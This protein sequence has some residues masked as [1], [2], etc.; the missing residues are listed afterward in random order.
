MT[1]IIKF[2]TPMLCLFTLLYFATLSPA[3]TKNSTWSVPLRGT[4]VQDDKAIAKDVMLAG[5]GKICEI[6]VGSKENSAVKQA[7]LFLATDIE[8]ICGVRPKI[9]KEPSKNVNSIRLNTVGDSKIPSEI[10]TASLKGQ[11]ESYRIA[12]FK[13]DVWLVGSDFRGTAFAA[14]TLSERLGI[15]PLSSGQVIAPSIIIP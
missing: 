10:E 6:V 5:N 15:D 7:A 8:K 3:Q 1:S 2:K 14:Y 4:W 11:W 12:T 13:Q 9:V